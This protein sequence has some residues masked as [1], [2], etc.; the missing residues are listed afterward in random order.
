MQPSQRKRNQ[1]NTKTKQVRLECA[2]SGWKC[3]RIHHYVDASCLANCFC[4]A[5]SMNIEDII[6][7]FLLSIEAYAAIFKRW[8]IPHE[9][10]AHNNSPYH[11]RIIE[12]KGLHSIYYVV[13]GTGKW[14]SLITFWE[15]SIW[16][17]MYIVCR[18]KRRHAESK[19]DTHL[20][21]AQVQSM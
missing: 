19:A 7:I 9:V 18:G 4:S 8:S 12:F 17:A 5:Y 2:T 6:C 1:T 14:A 10:G 11:G 15:W 16:A 3:V 13:N 20:A 21:E